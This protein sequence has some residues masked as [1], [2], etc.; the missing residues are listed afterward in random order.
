MGQWLRRC[1]TCAATWAQVCGGPAPAQPSP[2]PP[3]AATPRAEIP[4]R[5]GAAGGAGHGAGGDLD[6]REGGSLAARWVGVGLG[7]EGARG[8]LTRRRLG[9]KSGEE[10]GKTRGVC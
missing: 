9:R 8:A 3:R 10:K 1:L 4:A 5:A 6:P 7:Q 2:A